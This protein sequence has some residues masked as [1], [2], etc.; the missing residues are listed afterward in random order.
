MKMLEITFVAIKN[1][2]KLDKSVNHVC[3]TKIYIIRIKK[4]L[5]NALQDEH[6]PSLWS[7]EM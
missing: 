2:H 5:Q 4:L 6:L 3:F 7:I 1:K